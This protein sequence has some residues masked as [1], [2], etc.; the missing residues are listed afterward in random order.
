MIDVTESIPNIKPE[1]YP[2]KEFSYIDIS[3]INNST[4]QIIEPKRIN[5][6]EAPSRA[7]RPVRNGDV[8]FSNVRTYLR[9]IALVTSTVNADICSTGFTVLRPNES[10][11]SQF[12]FRY[13]LTDEFIDR[14]SPTQ[15]GTH[16]PATSDRAVL[17][18]YLPLPPLAEQRRIVA[19]LETLLGKVDAC[20]QRLAKIPVILK[21]FRQAVLAAACSGELTV[22]WRAENA[23]DYILLTHTEI[24]ENAIIELPIGWAAITLNECCTKVIDGNYGADYPKKDEFLSSGVPFLTSAAIGEDGKIIDAEIKF[25][26]SEKHSILKKAR[27]TLGDVLFTN[28]GARVGATTLLTD[29]KFANSN[30]GPQVTRLAANLERLL[31]T[32]LFYWMRNPFFLNVMKDKNGGSAMNF[33]NLTVT[34]SLPIFLPPLAEQQEIVC[35]VEALFQLADQLE[36]RYKRAKAQVD[37]LQQSIL[38]K[39]FRGELVPTEAELARREG[40]AYESAAALLERL[41][42]TRKGLTPATKPKSRPPKSP[43]SNGLLFD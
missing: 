17:A 18:E 29:S 8:L 6:S 38:A 33:L 37:K 43:A 14:V 11:E 10:V 4:N 28:R 7:R 15:T 20:Q 19:K 16:Y 3:S 13:V 9:N 2:N 12:L 41:R 5:G 1:D 36:A 34:K 42:Q 25:I 26:S 21:R 40:R 22:D 35:R 39:A 30:I 31:P 23:N 27:T 32:Y 24:D